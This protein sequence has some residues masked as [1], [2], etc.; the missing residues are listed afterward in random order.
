MGAEDTRSELRELTLAILRAQIAMLED[1]ARL[2]RVPLGD[3]AYLFSD[4]ADGREPWKPDAVSQYLGRLRGRSDLRQLTFHG[5]RKFMETYGQEMGY[6]ISQ[7]A[8][9]AGHN[10]SVAAPHYS[11]RVVET[12]RDRARAIASLL[13]A[14]ASPPLTE[15]RTH[16]QSDEPCGLLT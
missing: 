9:R 4:A 8:V 3:G 5:L 14:P 6:S 13:A 11:G 2:C 7:V 12:D 16:A 10:A 15:K 1:R